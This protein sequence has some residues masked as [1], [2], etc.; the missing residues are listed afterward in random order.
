[1]DD[2]NN[3]IEYGI[4]F[5]Y[6]CSRYGANEWTGRVP[7]DYWNYSCLFAPRRGRP[8]TEDEKLEIHR[9]TYCKEKISYAISEVEWQIIWKVKKELGFNSRRDINS[10]TIADLKLDEWITLTPELEKLL[11]DEKCING[12]FCFRCERVPNIRGHRG[13]YSCAIWNN[14]FSYTWE[15]MESST[16]IRRLAEF[17]DKLL[18]FI[19]EEAQARERRKIVKEKIRS[20]QITLEEAL[21][22]DCVAFLDLFESA[23]RGTCKCEHPGVSILWHIDNCLKDENQAEHFKNEMLRIIEIAL[24]NRVTNPNLITHQIAA[25]DAVNAHWNTNQTSGTVNG[26][27]KA[28]VLGATWENT[29]RALTIQADI[30][31][32]RDRLIGL[33]DTEKRLEKSH[34]GNKTS[35][36]TSF[37]QNNS[38]NAYSTS[39]NAGYSN[40]KSSYFSDDSSSSL[41]T[42]NNSS[43]NANIHNE[44]TNNPSS[45]SFTST[46]GNDIPGGGGGGYA[47][48][49]NSSSGGDSSISSSSSPPLNSPSKEKT[50]KPVKPKSLDTKES[51]N[52]EPLSLPEQNQIFKEKAIQ[53]IKTKLKDLPVDLRLLAN[54]QYQNWEQE[55]NQLTTVEQITAYQ[56]ALLQTIEEKKKQMKQNS[57]NSA[58]KQ[59]KDKNKNVIISIVVIGGILVVVL[60][61]LLVLWKRKK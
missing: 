44:Q 10:V 16:T 56:N 26:Q 51:N 15:L 52:S 9:R 4:N 46:G 17:R 22:A 31:K 57:L 54:N 28:D 43:N 6:F 45:S 36:S 30:D 2:N 3:N 38:S 11:Y 19:E 37:N 33:I 23:P 24:E 29:I 7:A 18:A 32:E 58:A 59:Y 8:L 20:S 27:S 53:E 42:T 49:V 25:I 48:P 39:S 5:D 47:P 40:S 35:S 12:F 13:D 61:G 50:T 55:I 34:Q 14:F 21:N 41:N 60:T 1:M